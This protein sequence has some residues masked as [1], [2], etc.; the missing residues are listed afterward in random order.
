ML[1][2]VRA[3]LIAVL[4]GVSMALV[5]L[6][7][8][9]TPDETWAGGLWD[10]D[11]FDHAFFAVASAVALVHSSQSDKGAPPLH[12]V[13]AVTEVPPGAAPSDAPSQHQP[14]S[15]PR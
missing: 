1:T 3:T 14:R 12:V 7:Y 4:I 15:P 11:D 2:S 8:A 13:G 5:P 10:D 6:T 9:G